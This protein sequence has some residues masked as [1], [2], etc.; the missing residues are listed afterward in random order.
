MLVILLVRFNTAIHSSAAVDRFLCFGTDILGAKRKSLSRENL[1][2]HASHD[3]IFHEKNS[4]T[5]TLIM[6]IVYR[7]LFRVLRF[8]RFVS[9]CYIIN[10]EYSFI[11]IMCLI[12]TLDVILFFVSYHF[13]HFVF[14]NFNR[15][16]VVL[17]D[18]KNF[19]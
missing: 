18:Y 8:V 19:M 5:K 16:G 2:E 3:K 9:F 11:L 15:F 14:Y 17:E 4:E 10:K 7:V 1:R 6:S 12:K 13:T